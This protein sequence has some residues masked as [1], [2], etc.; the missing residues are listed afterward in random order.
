MNYR[1]VIGEELTDEIIVN[2]D[3]ESAKK[4]LKR[5][6]Y[7][8]STIRKVYFLQEVPSIFRNLI[9]DEETLKNIFSYVRN[10]NFT[11]KGV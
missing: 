2:I 11:P 9:L 1:I 3:E 4:L 7:I 8:N 10:S 5:Q 6:G